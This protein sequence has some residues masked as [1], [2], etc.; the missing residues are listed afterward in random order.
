MDNGRIKEFVASVSPTSRRQ[1]SDLADRLRRELPQL[2]DTD[3][4]YMLSL[5][6][7]YTAGFTDG[8]YGRGGRPAGIDVLGEVLALAALDLTAMEWEA[9]DE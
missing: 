2:S 6:V 9:S 3:M 5:I 4:G 1:G 8:L 7:A